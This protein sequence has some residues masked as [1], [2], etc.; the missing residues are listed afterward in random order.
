M[1]KKTFNLVLA[2]ITIV[3]LLAAFALTSMSVE[4]SKNK[5]TTKAKTEVLGTWTDVN[6][7]QMIIQFT[8]EDQYKVMGQTEATYNVDPNNSI[9]TLSFTPEYGGMNQYYSYGFADN[10]SQ[11][12]MTNV[13]TGEI[14]QYTR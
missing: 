14:I 5:A 4:I 1:T 3:A 2:G 9:I 12:I 6:N 13:D 7:P 11:L 8:N 10:H